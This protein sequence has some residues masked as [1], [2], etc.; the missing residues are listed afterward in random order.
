MRRLL[1]HDRD[2]RALL[3]VLPVVPDPRLPEHLMPEAQLIARDLAV[4]GIFRKRIIR[5]HLEAVRRRAHPDHRAAAL[6]IIIEVPHLLGGKPL[7]TQEHHRKIRAVE[8][9]HARDVLRLAR[10]DVAVLIDVKQHRAFESLMLREDARQRRQRFLRAVLV[11]A[12]EEDDVLAFAGAVGA[13][14]NKRCGV[15]E[16]REREKSEEDAFHG[17]GMMGECLDVK[18]KDLRVSEDRG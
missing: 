2:A 1:R 17:I 7:K 13:L 8:R 4:V 15:R 9:L 12:R 11:I 3:V 14:E 5:A 6:Q 16:T 10:A 18:R